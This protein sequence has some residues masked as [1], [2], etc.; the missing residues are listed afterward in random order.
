MRS[1]FV[2]S[3]EEKSKR[4]RK[5][6]RES[7][8]L[9][10]SNG[11]ENVAISGNVEKSLATDEKKKKRMKFDNKSEDIRSE[12]SDNP[13]PSYLI[14][15]ED[16]Q[17]CVTFATIHQE[18]DSEEDDLWPM[19]V[20]EVSDE[21]NVDFKEEGFLDTETGLM[22]KPCVETNEYVKSP[23]DNEKYRFNQFPKNPLHLQHEEKRKR[24]IADE[25]LILEYVH[26]KFGVA[27][28]H[29]QRSL[30]GGQQLT[31]TAT[32]AEEMRNPVLSLDIQVQ[33]NSANKNR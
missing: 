19:S 16:S 6:G 23:T 32:E 33:D 2:L 9:S 17:T 13:G 3:E 26:K 11:E 4:F 8:E 22:V 21:S 20:A 30:T 14:S 1:A 5:Y 18:S 12:P 15:Q 7:D 28:V 27:T 24:S 10:E 29:E 25:N 31:G